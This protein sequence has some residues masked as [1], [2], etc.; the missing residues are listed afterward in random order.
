[1]DLK[2]MG[3]VPALH[4]HS[5]TYN[6]EEHFR[7][8]ES[9]MVSESGVEPFFRFQLAPLSDPTSAPEGST[10]FVMHYI[11]APST[12]W[13]D[14]EREHKTIELMIKRAEKVIPDLSRHIVYQE[15]WSPA[16]I[17]KYT[18][19]GIDASIGWALTP[20]QV[21]PRRL[22]PHTPVRNLY[23]SG[24]WTRPALG[25]MATVISGLHTAKTVLNKAGIS[26]PL[27]DLGI[28]RGVMA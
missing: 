2:Q 6:T 16:T 8:L 12:G 7:N 1:M 18:L 14:P 20:Q 10:A 9:K 5:S 3:L 21:G 25:V 22:S 23:L 27:A 26:E 28:K 4:I 11:P 15:F 13:D 19:S 24:H 17:D